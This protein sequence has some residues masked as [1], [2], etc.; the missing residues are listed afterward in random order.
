MAD[1]RLITPFVPY[2]RSVVNKKEEEEEEERGV[3]QVP[4]R[5]FTKV[6]TASRV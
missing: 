3:Q 4:S 2:L 5:K 6:F 1:T